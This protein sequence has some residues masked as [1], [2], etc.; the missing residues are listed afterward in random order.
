VQ[1]NDP[2]DEQ[3]SHSL[4]EDPVLASHI[5]DE[6]NDLLLTGEVQEEVLSSEMMIQQDNETTPVINE[7]E[8]SNSGCDLRYSHN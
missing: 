4:A 3:E 7:Y 8:L 2:V 5:G 1:N 6:E